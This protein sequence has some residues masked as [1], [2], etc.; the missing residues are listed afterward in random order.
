M[1]FVLRGDSEPQIAREL[2]GASPHWFAIYEKILSI[3]GSQK[4]FTK[5][6]EL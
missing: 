3:P 4:Y 5:G 1:E 6:C 2:R